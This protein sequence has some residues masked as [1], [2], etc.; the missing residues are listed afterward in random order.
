M[1]DAGAFL[2][3]G[4]DLDDKAGGTGT[5]IVAAGGTIKATAVHVGEGGRL[6]GSGGTIV[7]QV[8]N[9]GGTV[10]PGQSPGQLTIVG[11]YQSVGGTLRVDV[12]ANGNHDELTVMGNAIFDGVSR[13][14]IRLDPGFQPPAATAFNVI[15]MLPT[16]GGPAEPL[17]TVTVGAGGGA[18]TTGGPLAGLPTT[19]TVEP[20]AGQAAIVAAVLPASRSVTVG[21]TA[22][23]FVTV[24]NP[25][26]V[27]ATLVGIAPAAAL[28]AGFSYQ[29]TDPTTNALTGLPDVPVSIGAGQA[30]TFVIALTPTTTFGPTE[31]AF[32]FAGT[33]TVP[34]TPLVGINTLLLSA[35][36]TPVA[37]IVALAATVSNDGIV[38]IPGPRGTGAFAVATVNVGR[39]G[40]ITAAANFGG[41]SLP[42]AAFI[43]QTNPGTG[44][45]Q[46]AP[47]ARVTVQIDAGQTPTFSIFVQGSGTIPLDA[48][49]NRVFVEFRDAGDVVRGK[50]SVAVRTQ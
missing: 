30:Q 43:C 36:S 25:G 16:P 18:A 35:S 6:G 9:L 34:V 4:R 11:S 2:G 31:V 41:A 26:P 12:D 37:D 44:Q 17:L 7:G 49:A 28:G 42:A 24:L 39:G 48:A 33:N 29:T 1:L 13:I 10:S 3:I 27:S 8:V 5:V 45:C 19:V 23:A 21:R 46:D 40:A 47:G 14:D 15:Q 22:T 38:N 50:T 20:V 32:A